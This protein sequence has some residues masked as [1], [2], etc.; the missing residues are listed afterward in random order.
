[1]GRASGSSTRHLQMISSYRR[2]G[3]NSGRA[4]R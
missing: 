1:V 4:N 2:F 3:Q